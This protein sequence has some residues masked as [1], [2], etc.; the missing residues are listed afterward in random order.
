MA[1]LV[2]VGVTVLCPWQASRSCARGDHLLA[3]DP[4]A[5]QHQYRRAARWDADRDVYYVKLS[6]A[7]QLCAR[8]D[9]TTAERQRDFGQARDLL[10]QAIALTPADAYHHASLARLLGEVACYDATDPQPV[11]ATWDRALQMDSNNV[12][13]IAEATR[14]ALA[15]GDRARARRLARQGLSLSPDFALFHAQ[16]G[17]CSLAEG[18]IGEAAEFYEHAVNADWQGNVED[19]ARACAALA[20]CHLNLRHPEYARDLARRACVLQPHWPVAAVFLAQALEALGDDEEAYRTYQ[21][22]LI[23]AP[24]D[25]GAAI[26][27][28]RLAGRLRHTPTILGPAE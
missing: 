18:R 23:I 8:H 14:G 10:Q 1:A 25:P 21:R 7:T 22:V 4:I 3:D 16:L 19:E 6:A 2:L 13:F 20:S 26:A 15:L 17:A 27:L 28:Q 12:G 24:H 11:A 9:S 5:A